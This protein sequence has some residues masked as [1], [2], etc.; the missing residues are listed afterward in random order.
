MPLEILSPCKVNLIL[1]ILGRRPD[2]YHDLETIFCPVPVHDILTF[3][4]QSGGVSLS[5]S[6]PALPSDSQNL[7]YRAA[8]AF[9]QASGVQCGIRIC[10]KKNLPLA[11]GLGGGSANAAITLNA[12]NGLF[13]NAL[14]PAQLRDLAAQLGSDVPFFLQGGPALGE[15][16]G[17]KIQPLSPFP[18]L[19][20]FWILLLHPGFGVSTAWAYSNLGRFPA[21]LNGTPGRAERLIQAL[22]TGSCLEAKPHFYNSLEAPVF[23]KHPILGLYKE[24]LLAHGAAVALMSGSGST[25]FALYQD[26]RQAEAALDRFKEKYGTVC[27]TALAPISISQAG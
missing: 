13:E 7:V 1:N 2:G 19:Q 5:C 6:D 25:T 21:A 27:W 20:D 18:A 4:K 3:D 12:L 22:R 14:T 26:K 24:F 10:L 17:E 16:R 15:G 23:E 11:A 9:L 8:Q